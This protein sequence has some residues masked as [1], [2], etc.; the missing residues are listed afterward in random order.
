MSAS[1]IVE[2]LR[3]LIVEAIDEIDDVEINGVG[4]KFIL[5]RPHFSPEL[6]TAPGTLVT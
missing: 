4:V 1:S 3:V 2:R 5:L 6:L